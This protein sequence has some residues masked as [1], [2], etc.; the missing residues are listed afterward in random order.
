MASLFLQYSGS[1][2]Y[3]RSIPGYPNSLAK[4][5]SLN[6]SNLILAILDCDGAYVLDH[7]QRQEPTKLFH[8]KH[9][10]LN[11]D[12][13]QGEELSL[14]WNRWSRN[15]E[16]FI[17]LNIHQDFIASGCAAMVLVVPIRSYGLITTIRY[18]GRRTTEARSRR[19]ETQEAVRKPIILDF[20]S[21]YFSKFTN[22]QSDPIILDFD[23]DYSEPRLASPFPQNPK[24]IDPTDNQSIAFNTCVTP[25]CIRRCNCSPFFPLK[26]NLDLKLRTPPSPSTPLYGAVTNTRDLILHP[27]LFTDAFRHT[28]HS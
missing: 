8:L 23:S 27:F 14:Y 20:D 7:S 15:Y 2:F 18:H 10:D 6:P 16:T 28:A 24:K 5:R 12:M 1:F 11:S 9:L 3:L 4:K 21:D 26:E 25:N 19:I 17:W 13:E 22:V